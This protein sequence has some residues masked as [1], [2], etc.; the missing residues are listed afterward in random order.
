MDQELA[1]ARGSE[2]AGSGA[3]ALRTIESMY[4]KNFVTE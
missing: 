4:G 3:N 2:Q 1:L